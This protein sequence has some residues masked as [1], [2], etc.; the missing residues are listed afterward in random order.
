MSRLVMV[1]HG[2]AVLI[3]TAEE[4]RAQSSRRSCSAA[5][6]APWSRDEIFALARRM[7]RQLRDGLNRAARYLRALGVELEEALQALFPGRAV[8][9]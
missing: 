6:D 2:G 4:V 8:I 1:P 9:Q 5:H 3:L 7:A